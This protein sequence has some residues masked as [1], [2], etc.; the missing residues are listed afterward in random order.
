MTQESLA[1]IRV[2]DV[3]MVYNDGNHN[4]IYDLCRVKGR[5]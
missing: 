3:R 2:E 5:Y 4:A 1:T